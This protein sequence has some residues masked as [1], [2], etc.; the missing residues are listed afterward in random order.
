MNSIHKLQDSI[1]TILINNGLTELSFNDKDELT[2]PT[3]I[4][5]YDNDCQPYEDPVLKV[6]L[7]ETGLSVELD[8][9]NF[10]NTVKVYDYD[11]DR[12]EW[13]E[14]IHANILEILERDS[15]RRCPVCGKPLVGNK[16]YCT[17]DCRHVMASP[18]TVEQ[19]LAKANRNIHRLAKLAAGKD[20][21]YLKQL[22]NKYTISV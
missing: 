13:W 10:G 15:R 17:A 22:M 7:K 14:G 12:K 21:R 11:I 19:A 5:W 1:R 3:Y 4:I 20:K 6:Y 9:R 2:D 18:L 16:K 8:A